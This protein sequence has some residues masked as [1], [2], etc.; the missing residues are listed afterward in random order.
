MAA[1]GLP[2]DRVL[3]DGGLPHRGLIAAYGGIDIALDPFP[4]T[5][6]LT[7]CEALWMGVPVVALAG[8]SFC[9]RHALSHLSNVGLAD[10]VAQDTAGYVAL[11]VARRATWPGWRGCGKGCGRGSRPRRWSMRRASG[12]GWR[13][14]CARPGTWPP[15]SES[16]RQAAWVAVT[17][18]SAWAKHGPSGRNRRR[19]LAVPVF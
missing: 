16:A 17:F 13:R 10:W 19:P 4:Y 11:A 12:R 6:G 7:V 14:H 5:G 3:L 9:A 15:L 18:S 2:P 8:D 1:A